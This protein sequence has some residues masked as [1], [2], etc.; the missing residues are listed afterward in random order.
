MTSWAKDLDRMLALIG[1]IAAS[2]LI[3]YTLLMGLSPQYIL[4]AT[5]M[6]AVCLYWTIGRKRLQPREL[7]GAPAFSDRTV[8]ALSIVF[9]VLLTLSILSVQFRTS[10]YQRPL[11]Y[12]I[13]TAVMVGVVGIQTLVAKG[14]WAY[15]VLA[16]TIVI[17]LSL[18][19]SQLFIFPGVMQAD[20]WYHQ[21]F[22]Q[23]MLDEHHI[24]DFSYSNMPLFHLLVGST[25]LIDNFDYKTAMV[26]SV[27]LGQII[28]LV[29]SIFLLGRLVTGSSRIGMLGAL[30]VAFSDHF[31]MMAATAIPGSLAAAFVP[32]MLFMLLL[33]P[34]KG[35]L[36][37]GIAAF[38]MG[39]VVL[40]HTITSTWVAAFMSVGIVA[41]FIA[42]KRERWERISTPALF[43]FF[44]T[45]MIG[46]WGYASG[47][48]DYLAELLKLGFSKE[49]VEPSRMLL[50]LPIQEQ[51]LVAAGMYVM[52]ALSLIGTFYLMA[53]WR[54]NRCFEMALILV[55]P[56]AIGF[57]S[58]LT[59]LFINQQ[60]W[61]FFAQ[62][63]LAVPAA[64]SLYLI[65]GLP[66]RRKTRMA[67]MGC[68]T[69]VVAFLMI[70]GG[71]ANT[72]N[73]FLSPTITVRGGATLGEL[74]AAQTTSGMGPPPAVDSTYANPFLLWVGYDFMR[75][76]DALID[77]DF[78]S[79]DGHLVLIRDA[80]ADGSTFD[81]TGGLYRL[82]YPVEEVLYSSGYSKIYDDAS[83][84]GYLRT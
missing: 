25:S 65:F 72:D 40:T 31:T 3:V 21:L 54:R 19:W 14:R 64:I 77:R 28:V 52:F 29:L 69:A 61:F 70:S 62:I 51:L 47:D 78:N 83:V 1:V 17:G 59:G 38:L 81:I 5:M 44:I 80:V 67:A 58:M 36:A 82:D 15:M 42:G 7:D 68:I 35:G 56:L 37:I 2:F 4:V 46:W 9:F 48:V 60:R 71:I 66:S 43:A 50:N 11:E 16:Q 53:R 20:P 12:F 8:I 41:S 27:S 57:L 63:A 76:D 79:T 18:A 24:P 74:A 34:R 49:L 10:L 84:S 23:L 33:A 26:L 73:P 22:T 6:G 55:T 30:I 39:A 75:L 45:I 13:I 32:L